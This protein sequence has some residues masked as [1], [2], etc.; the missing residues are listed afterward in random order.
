MKET[1]NYNDLTFRNYGAVYNYEGHRLSY[2]NQ[3]IDSK[4][5][6]MKNVDN[7]KEKIRANTYTINILLLIIH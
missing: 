7:A 5:W 2:Q 3:G 6:D 1:E 4:I